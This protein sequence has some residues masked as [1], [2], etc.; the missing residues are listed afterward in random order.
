MT[1]KELLLCL[2]PN[3]GEFF[4]INEEHSCNKKGGG[5]IDAKT[6]A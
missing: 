5:V 4:D 3:E 1:I 6:V 2:K